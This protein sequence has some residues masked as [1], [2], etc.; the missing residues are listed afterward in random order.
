VITPVVVDPP[1]CHVCGQ[2]VTV[3]RRDL[4]QRPQHEDTIREYTM[5][6][7]ERHV[8]VRQVLVDPPPF[9]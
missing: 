4:D 7:P 9:P 2:P 1:V 3:Q 8:S 6:C 5:A